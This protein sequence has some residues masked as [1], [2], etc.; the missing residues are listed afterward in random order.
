MKKLLLY[1]HAKIASPK[2][3]SDAQNLIEDLFASGGPGAKLNSLIR[4]THSG[5]LC[6]DRVYPGKHMRDS[7]GSFVSVERGGTASYDKPVLIHHRQS[8]GGGLFGGGVPAEDPIGRIRKA[9]FVQL[10]QGDDFLRDYRK[11]G[12]GTDHGSG[13][14]NVLAE[15]SDPAAIQKILDGRY[16]SVSVGFTTHKALCSVCGEDWLADSAG[17][18]EHRPGRT[19]EIDDNTFKCF[20]VTGLMDYREVSFVNI[21]GS[22]NAKTISNNLQALEGAMKGDSEKPFESFSNMSVDKLMLS[23]SEGHSL[24]LILQDGQ[25]DVLP[26]VAAKLRG[27]VM[28]AVPDGVDKINKEDTVVPDDKKDEDSVT[29]SPVADGVIGDWINNNDDERNKAKDG[30]NTVDD[31][32]KPK[33]GEGDIVDNEPKAPKADGDDAEKHALRESL[34]SM[35]QERDELKEKVKTLQAAVDVNTSLNNELTDELRALKAQRVRDAARQL[36]VINANLNKPGAIGL[37]DKVKFDAYVDSLS[38]RSIDSLLD[39]IADTL[40]ELDAHMSRLAKKN[41][42]DVKVEDPTINKKPDVRT[43]NRKASISVE[44]FLNDL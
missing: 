44:D 5:Y 37:S 7:V 42:E 31:N 13:Y 1:D 40:P 3:Y 9:Q 25:E 16:S 15:I 2:L 35:T 6:N 8:D 27:K 33:D 30:G 43:D 34:T 24:D 19:Y 14:I 12:R 22:P 11:P 39:S 28:V 21:P 32:D 4:A 10:K 17:D 20:L 38:E 36:A 41:L 23:D 29:P 18:C 26:D